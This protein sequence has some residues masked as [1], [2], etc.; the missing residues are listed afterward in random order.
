M[1]VVRSERAPAPIGPYSQA[2][3]TGDLLFVSG[4]LGADPLSGELKEGIRAQAVQA[5]DNLVNILKEEGL[6][7]N[8]VVKTTVY[9]KDMGDFAEFNAVYASYFD[10]SYFPART[11]IQVGALPK[12]GMIEIEAIASGDR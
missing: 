6:G 4:C 10:G 1:R 3:K 5:M 2:V 7:V 9:L 12:G 11:C 8:N